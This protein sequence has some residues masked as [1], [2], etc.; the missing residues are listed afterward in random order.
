MKFYFNDC[1]IKQRT[2]TSKYACYDLDGNLI[3]KYT[4]DTI[5]S[6]MLNEIK[7]IE[8][9]LS[10]PEKFF[11][12]ETSFSGKVEIVDIVDKNI[13][14][15]IIPEKIDGCDVTDFETMAKIN[16]PE[17]R[18]ISLPSCF[19]RYPAYM[20]AKSKHL[21]VVEIADG[22]E[23]SKGAFSNHTEIVSI[24]LPSDLKIMPSAC[25]YNCMSLKEI[26]LENIEEFEASSFER[27]FSLDPT[28]SKNVK[29]FGS[30]SFLKSGITK[31]NLENVEKIE[32][33]AFAQCEKLNS[34]NI[35]I[36]NSDKK[37]IAENAFVAILDD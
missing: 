13:Q 22:V 34:E 1:V 8:L 30:K 36:K 17:L 24:K 16:L 26:N 28:F 10:S 2:Q 29:I 11:I 7:N 20:L 19:R 6:E 37:K 18:Y 35:N 14:N 5:P 25:C 21:K 4:Q 31:L 15:L 3:T 12:F 32:A 23:V 9:Q 27:C 33:G